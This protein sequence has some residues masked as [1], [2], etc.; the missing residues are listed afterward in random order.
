LLPV[1][2]QWNVKIQKIAEKIAEKTIDNQK[3]AGRS[4]LHTP[5]PQFPRLTTTHLAVEGLNGLSYSHRHNGAVP[6]S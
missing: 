3:P 2:G 4:T 1:E 6:A 5:A